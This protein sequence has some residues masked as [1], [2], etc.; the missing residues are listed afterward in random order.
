[1]LRMSNWPTLGVEVVQSDRGGGYYVFMGRGN[2]WVYPILR[3][4]DRKLSVGGYVR[5]LE[6]GVIAAL[7]EMG[8]EARKDPS[9]IGVWG[10]QCEGGGGERFV[11]WGC[12]FGGGVTLHGIALNVTTDLR[13]FELIVPCGLVGERGDV[14]EGD[15]GGRVRR[16]CGAGWKGGG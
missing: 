4:Q 13:Y 15:V 11:R 16:G 10:E 12:G 2:W 5:A 6:M 7:G 1:L 8:I 3:L 14:D 9:A